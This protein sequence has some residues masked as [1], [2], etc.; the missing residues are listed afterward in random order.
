MAS[1]AL[2]LVAKIQVARVF[3]LQQIVLL[4]PLFETRSPLAYPLLGRGAPSHRPFLERRRKGFRQGR[5]RTNSTN[6]SREV[7]KATNLLFAGWEAN[8]FRSTPFGN[9]QPT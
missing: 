6:A 3:R 7:T 1:S 5:R 8:A 4:H 2:K 9:P